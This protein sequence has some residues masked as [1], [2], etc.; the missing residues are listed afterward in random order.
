LCS[1]VLGQYQITDLGTLGG[2]YSGAGFIN[3]KGQIAGDAQFSST[4]PYVATLFDS[5]GMGN[6]INFGTYP[7]YPSSG[8]SSINS[9][10]KMVG[11]AGND[12]NQHCA[13][14]FDSTGA[15]NNVCLGNLS[16]LAGFSD[17]VN[18]SACSINDQDMI[19]GNSFVYINYTAR[20]R[21]TLFDPT[22]SG[23]NIDLGTLGGP[24]SFAFSVNNHN[25]IVGW[26]SNSNNDRYA[27]LFDPTGS[28]NNKNLGVATGGLWSSAWSIN[29]KGQIVGETSYDLGRYQRHATLFDITGSGNNIDL[30]TLS[31]GGK[32]WARCINNNG[33]IVGY[34]DSSGYDR[35]TLFDP[36]GAGNN[37]DLNTLIP[38][39]SGWTLRQACS[40]NDNGWIVG[41]GKSPSG[42]DHAFLLKPIPEPCTLGLLALGGA[43]ISRRKV[44]R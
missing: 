3:N 2:T 31:N 9:N 25:Q 17:Y 26:A 39:N 33:Q 32:S 42:K 36:T 11:G 16:H 28:G 14:L 13:L 30:G 15:G 12:S 8:I 38:A 44:N 7:G 27:T 29:D 5:S 41:I 19:V 20:Y 4:G 24:Y 35:A 43:L 37:I 21:A 18:S 1:T 40:I 22:G 34:A 23:N 10:G 6:N